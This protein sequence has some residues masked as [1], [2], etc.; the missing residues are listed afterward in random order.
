MDVHNV[1]KWLSC[2]DDSKTGIFNLDGRYITEAKEKEHDLEIVLH[3]PHTTGQSYLAAV[4]KILQDEHCHSLG[5][6]AS[7]VLVKEY[8]NYRV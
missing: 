5:V 4:S 3:N 8:Q 2:F 6:E 1:R 7:E